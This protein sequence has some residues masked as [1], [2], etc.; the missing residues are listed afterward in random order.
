MTNENN[1]EECPALPG[2]FAGLSVDGLDIAA[3]IERYHDAYPEIL[4]SYYADTA[5]LLEKARSLP[6]GDFSADKLR[7]YAITV[8]GIKG[9]SYGIRAN[10]MGALAEFMEHT[11]RAGDVQTIRIQNGRF[12]EIA[13]EFLSGLEDLLRKITPAK[14]Q[15]S[16]AAPDSASLRKLADACARYDIRQMEAALAE[17]EQF[18]YRSGG[19]L[20][21]W[22]RMQADS[23][24]YDAIVD[25]LAGHAANGKNP[26]AR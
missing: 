7:E 20:V 4:R 8:H 9:S 6:E 23:L 25:R 17:L 22:L 13:E 11:A 24:E 18:D 2:S 12:V 5:A 19:D 10:G 26:P 16:A 1:I 3:G 15:Q 21:R 14:K